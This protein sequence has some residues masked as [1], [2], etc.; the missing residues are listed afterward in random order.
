MHPLKSNQVAERLFPKLST[1]EKRPILV[2]YVTMQKG[3]EFET[4]RDDVSGTS[5]GWMGGQTESLGSF[6]PRLITR[7]SEP[8]L[9]PAFLS[10]L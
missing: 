1:K 8:L 10:V 9:V 5:K 7:H 6:E 3:C 2:S 4:V